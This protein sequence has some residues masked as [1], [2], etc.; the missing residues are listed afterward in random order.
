MIQYLRAGLWD[1]N[2]A[3]QILRLVS[4]LVS[5][6]STSY[7]FLHISFKSPTVDNLLLAKTPLFTF[8]IMSTWRFWH[9][10]LQIFKIPRLVQCSFFFPHPATELGNIHI[11]CCRSIFSIVISHRHSTIRKPAEIS[12]IKF[13]KTSKVY[14]FMSS[15]VQCQQL[16]NWS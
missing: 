14:F 2:T 8:V 7:M 12:N 3:L 9:W 15:W 5:F 11:N 10:V 16:R 13:Q 6:T 1:V 4:I